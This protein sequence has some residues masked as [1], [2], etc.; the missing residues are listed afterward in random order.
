V[1][2]RS[3]RYLAF[4]NDLVR[5]GR[6]DEALRHAPRERAG[7]AGE[8]GPLIVGRT[9]DGGF[10]LRAD[11]DGD[12]WR[13]DLPALMIDW[14]AACAFAAWESERTGLPWRLPT[15]FEW[16]KAAR[17]VDG[18]RY[19]WGDHPDATWMCV[20][21]SHDGKAQPPAVGSFPLDESPYGVRWMAGGV[22]DWCLDVGREAG[23]PTDGDRVVVPTVDP[24]TADP[25]E[26]RAYR[27]GDWYG[28]AVHARLAYRA[29]NKPRTKN[30]SLGF[31]LCRSVG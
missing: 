15:E 2:F 30:Y 6:V 31:R 3:A 7:A 18:R 25:E 22:R 9:P 5:R 17:G 11:A 10:C 27:G 16:E 4:L 28:L 26:P 13:P 14:Y 19:P 29:W 20:R 8:E 12:E 1:L 21:A 24:A 23:P